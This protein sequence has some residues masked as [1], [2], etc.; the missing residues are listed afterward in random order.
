[1]STGLVE[2][3]RGVQVLPT[4][5][6]H[7]PTHALDGQPRAVCPTREAVHASQEVP[8]AIWLIPTRVSPLRA[9]IAM[10]PRRAEAVALQCQRRVEIG[11][12][13]AALL[14]WLPCRVAA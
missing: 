5:L 3:W 13:Q 4:G 6:D 12:Q 7:F 1:M 2:A 9:P 10:G 14:Q 8:D 11:R